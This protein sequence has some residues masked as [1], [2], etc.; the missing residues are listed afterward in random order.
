MIFYFS[1]SLKCISSA[2]TDMCISQI[3]IPSDAISNSSA[4]PNTYT[5]VV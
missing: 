2:F 3:E 4:M 5:A 1:I